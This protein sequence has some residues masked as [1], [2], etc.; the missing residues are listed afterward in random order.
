MGSNRAVWTWLGGYRFPSRPRGILVGWC[1]DFK[2]GGEAQEKS[3]FVRA[4]RFLA[5]A[6]QQA[7]DL[8]SGRP[9]A[10]GP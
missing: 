5:W 3:F 4:A 10:T 6:S 2:A 7:K 1:G 9:M 8:S